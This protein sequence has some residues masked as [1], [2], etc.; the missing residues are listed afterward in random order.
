MGEIIS[1]IIGVSAV[2][3]VAGVLIAHFVRKKNGKPGCGDCT[4]C[5]YSK[6]CGKNAENP[7]DEK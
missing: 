7:R 6:D 3:I 2:L 5:S 4:G 1:I